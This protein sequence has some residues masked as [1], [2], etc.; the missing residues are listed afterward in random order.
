MRPI[1]ATIRPERIMSSADVLLHTLRLD[2]PV[3]RRL[4]LRAPWGAKIDGCPR[5]GMYVVERGG[6]L[7]ADGHREVRAETGDLLLF[8]SGGAHRILDRPSTPARVLTRE[9]CAGEEI[10]Y[11]GHGDLTGVYAITFAGAPLPT[12]L[13]SIVPRLVHVRPAEL[14]TAGR[15]IVGAIG[16]LL[17]TGRPEDREPIARLSESLLLRV[18]RD[19]WPE[20]HL[21]V[22]DWQIV[23]SIAHVE[24]DPGAFHSVDTLARR[25]GLGRSRFVERFRSLTGLSPMRFV[26]D[27][28]MA[29]ALTLLEGGATRVSEVAETC[30]YTSVTAFRKALRRHHERTSGAPS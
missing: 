27:R 14:D 20:R 28:R 16:E 18:L 24:R 3:V 8:P 10:R 19:R 26:T 12:S 23:A 25:A 5:P 7:F 22:H 15:H 9:M 17:E 4:E 21:A 2:S 6:S 11:G 29:L 30:G 1:L 13:H